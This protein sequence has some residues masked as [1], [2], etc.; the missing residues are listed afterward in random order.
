MKDLTFYNENLFYGASPKIIQFAREL[1]NNLTEAE[2]ILWQ[3]LRNRKLD[4]YKFRRQHPIDEFIV[5]FYCHEIK[6]VVELD[7]GIHNVPEVK[8]YDISRSEELEMFDI[9]IIRFKNEEVF[10][11]LEDVLKKIRQELNHLNP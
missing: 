8:E 10:Q 11:D 2:N 6:L 3:K 4:G 1:R 7:G 9:K 5:D